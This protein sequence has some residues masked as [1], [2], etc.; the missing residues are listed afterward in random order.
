M[1]FHSTMTNRALIEEASRYGYVSNS[2]GLRVSGSSLPNSFYFG[3]TPEGEYYDHS[4]MLRE[5]T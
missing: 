1:D 5:D 2:W 4:G 3:R